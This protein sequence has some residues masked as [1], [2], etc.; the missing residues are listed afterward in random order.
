MGKPPRYQS[1]KKI[2]RLDQRKSFPVVP[3]HQ[4]AKHTLYLFPKKR[5]SYGNTFPSPVVK[6]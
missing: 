6:K 4:G 3:I 1:G 5:P 2:G